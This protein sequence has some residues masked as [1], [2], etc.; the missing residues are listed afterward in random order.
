MVFVFFSWLS[1]KRVYDGL[2]KQAKQAID[3]NSGMVL[4]R[5]LSS[6]IFGKE[7]QEMYKQ[8]KNDPKRNVITVSEAEGKKRFA[9]LFK[10][11]HN[12]WIENTPN[13]RQ[14]YDTLMDI[15]ADIRKGQ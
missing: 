14:K 7:S 10:P 6:D 9:Q 5:R 12:K 13:G 3:K 2:P 8:A 15:I 4:S 11:F 1:T